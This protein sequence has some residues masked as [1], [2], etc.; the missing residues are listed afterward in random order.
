LFIEEE[1]LGDKVFEELGEANHHFPPHPRY[2]FK[3]IIVLRSI[4]MNILPLESVSKTD[5]KG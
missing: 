2:A 4:L 5:W 3:D 1:E